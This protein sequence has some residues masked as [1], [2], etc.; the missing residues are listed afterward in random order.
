MFMICRNITMNLCYKAKL[1]SLEAYPV[2]TKY[3]LDQLEKN[4]TRL[5][6]TK[7]Y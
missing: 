5:C 1:W 7:K 3:T 6:F 4:T 2:K